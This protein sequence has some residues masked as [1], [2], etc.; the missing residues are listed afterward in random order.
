MAVDDDDKRD[1]SLDPWAEADGEGLPDLS[2]D[3]FASLDDDLPV[4]GGTAGGPPPESGVSDLAEPPGGNPAAFEAAA[5]DSDIDAWLNEPGDPPRP[6]LSVFQEEDHEELLGGFTDGSDQ[7]AV[8]RS[9]VEIGTGQSGVPSASS[10]ELTDESRSDEDHAAG[11]A[12]PVAE[13]LLPDFGLFADAD[14]EAEPDPVAGPPLHDAVDAIDDEEPVVA[15]EE[16]GA[17]AGTAA[18]VAVAAAA[19]APKKPSGLGSLLG[20]VAGGLL[21]IP[22]TLGILL[23]GFGRD[24]L[25]LA[26]IMP[27][28]LRFMVP[29]AMRPVPFTPP[30]APLA[31]VEPSRGDESADTAALTES[32][33]ELVPSTPAEPLVADASSDDGEPLPS[34]DEAPDEAT[35]AI[36]S[37]VAVGRELDANPRMAP[38]E[39]MPDDPIAVTPAIEPEAAALMAAVDPPVPPP[40]D[41]PQVAAASEPLDVTDLATAARQAVAETEAFAAEAESAAPGRRRMVDWYRTLAGYAESLAV[42]EREAVDTGRSFE[43]AA[44]SVA[45][46]HRELAARPHVHDQLARLTRDWIDYPGRQT[47]G[48]VVP[49]VF[50]GTRPVGP[51]W[52]SVVRIGDTEGR[53]DREMVVVT[54]TEPLAEIEENVLITGVALDGGVLWA[55]DV[56]PAAIPAADERAP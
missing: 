5:A 54:R 16:A 29:A 32:A 10:L 6:A 22:I 52:R 11:A 26:T 50:L 33:D 7:L 56:R 55:S 23:W 38:T 3:F 39:D 13:E 53:P 48:V 40:A 31:T 9:S 51:W 24:P 47:D 36:A 49:A 44:E 35:A 8:D 42:T 20:I 18:A 2:A 4:E 46:V 14:L 43:A 30:A 17:A 21:A 15:F 12:G 34:E 19:P 27:D 25:G 37:D 1:D 41:V 45:A 28:S